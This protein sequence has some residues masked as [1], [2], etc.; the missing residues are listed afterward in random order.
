MLPFRSTMPPL[1]GLT[2]P[3]SGK[4]SETIRDDQC[5]VE[6][7]ALVE[8]P[9]QHSIHD[10]TCNGAVVA[11]SIMHE[12][13]VGGP[14]IMSKLGKSTLTPSVHHTHFLR[15]GQYHISSVGP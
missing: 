12:E 7:M 13:S 9:R 5:I 8:S 11:L 4:A 3:Y 14:T 1:K 15:G 2:C 6:P 10:A